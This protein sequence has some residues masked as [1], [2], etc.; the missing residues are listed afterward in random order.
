MTQGEIGSLIAL[1]LRAGQSDVAVA[2]LITHVVVSLED[3]AFSAPAKP[4]GP[5][6]TAERA[7]ELAFE[8]GWTVGA[9]AGRGHRRL[10]ASPRPIEVVETVAIKAL[11]ERGTIVVACGGGGVPVSASSAGLVGVEAVID[12]DYVAGQLA[13]ALAAQAVV[14][15]TDV[16]RLMLDFG[17]P[18]ERAVDEIDVA[19]AERHQRDGQFPAGSMGPKVHAATQFLR[20]G[21]ELAVI[22]APQLAAHTLGP[23]G[24]AAINGSNLERGTRIVAT[25]LRE[26]TTQ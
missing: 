7:A 14:F 12:K 19:G 20:S 24:E 5:F 3:P 21:G 4:I 1:A 25:R 22:S 23:P 10:V 16:P 15:V 11:V 8:R 6:F 26:R 9:D 18:T 17:L 2:V 13:T